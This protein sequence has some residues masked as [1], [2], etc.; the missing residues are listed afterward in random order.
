MLDIYDVSPIYSY[1]VEYYRDFGEDHFDDYSDSQ[2]DTMLTNA[3]KEKDSYIDD[4]EN[5]THNPSFV[6]KERLVNVEE[7]IKR[8]NKEIEKR[9]EE[10]SK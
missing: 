8:L 10:K 4:I 6:L 9:K 1:K 7:Y 5:S 3:I 2:L